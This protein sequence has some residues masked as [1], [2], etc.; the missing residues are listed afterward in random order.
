MKTYFLFIMIFSLLLATMPPCH[1]LVSKDFAKAEICKACREGTTLKP[2]DW[3]TV[4]RGAVTQ[5][6]VIAILDQ[7]ASNTP[8]QKDD[9]DNQ[10]NP[11]DPNDTTS[12][13]GRASGSNIEAVKQ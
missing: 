13:V 2:N 11:I 4:F 1:A 10:K 5:D 12:S 8:P 3:V 7:C 9:D 6:E